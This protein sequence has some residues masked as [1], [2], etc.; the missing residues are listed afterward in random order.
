MP[1]HRRHA[2]SAPQSEVT[3]RSDAIDAAVETAARIPKSAAAAL[4]TRVAAARWGDSAQAAAVRFEKM[5]DSVEVLPMQLQAKPAAML[6]R[7]MSELPECT[8]PALN[9]RFERLA[10]GM[11]PGS[12]AP[13]LAALI[14]H[15][16]SGERV[17]AGAASSLQTL[18]AQA[19]RLP[20]PVRAHALGAAFTRLSAIP[21][22]HRMQ[23]FTEWL[24]A[25]AK[26][27]ADAAHAQA[28]AAAAHALPDLEITQRTGAASAI[29][30]QTRRLGRAD[31]SEPLT[32][33]AGTPG[34]LPP[35]ARG[36][37]MHAVLATIEELPVAV[38]TPALHAVIDA[39]TSLPVGVRG[40]FLERVLDAAASDASLHA[41]VVERALHRLATLEL[42]AE[43]HATLFDL[44]AAR[45][46]D[47]P[48]SE[49][50]SA[51]LVYAA[52]ELPAAYLPARAT[53]ALDAVTSLPPGRRYAPL[54]AA[55]SLLRIMPSGARRERAFETALAACA[56]D[57]DAAPALEAL[58]RELRLLPPKSAR[59]AVFRFAAILRDLPMAQRH[60]P[61]RLLLAKIDVL[62]PGDRPAARVTLATA[63]RAPEA[64]LST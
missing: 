14:V 18:V 53:V 22:A 51:A 50:V 40:H 26:T 15:A 13:L 28:L 31:R 36:P 64:S 57:I 45:A 52:A 54:A 46:A 19:P 59:F 37:R 6:V 56:H 11:S 34:A 3:M 29:L 16:A 1:T 49:D 23:R 8:R 44:A 27:P 17:A 47:F 43:E 61:I 48:P 32:A 33:L 39:L 41:A 2:L 20:R 35:G 10:A 63:L 9:I 21:S 60:E 58:A 24:Q 7:R 30:A 25:L 12:F 38:R 62:D 42:R 55:P 4:L 5:L